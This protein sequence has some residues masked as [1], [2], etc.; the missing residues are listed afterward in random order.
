MH[1]Y[2]HINSY[3]VYTWCANW[4]QAVILIHI[5][6][7]ISRCICSLLTLTRAGLCVRELAM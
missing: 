4:E 7:H 3:I 2:I 1:V 5:I 6:H